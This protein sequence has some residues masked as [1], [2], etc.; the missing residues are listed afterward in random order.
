MFVNWRKNKIN[1]LDTPGFDDFV[2]EVI[3]SLK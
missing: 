1:I 2:G 3:A